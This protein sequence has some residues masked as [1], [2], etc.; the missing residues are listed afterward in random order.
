MGSQTVCARRLIAKLARFFLRLRPDVVHTHDQRALFYAGPAARLTRVPTIVH[1]RHGRDVHAT[2][3]QTMMIRHLSKLVDRFVCVS[4]EVA[5]LSREQGVA[6]SRLR[7]IL[8]GIDVSRFGFNGPDAAGPV[9]TVARLS[10]EKDVANLVRA[11]AIAAQRAPDLRVEIAGGG[12]CL[13]ELQLLAAGTGAASALLFWA[14]SVT[15]PG[16][17]PEPG[18]LCCPR[19]PRGSR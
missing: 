10:P 2:P 14:R 5:E 3:R 11:T 18:C 8:N 13:E 6:G 17:S 4:E 15:S 1:T 7:T 19:G 16:C 12:P 9:V